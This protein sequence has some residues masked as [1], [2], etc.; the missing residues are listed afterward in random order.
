MLPIAI[1]IVWLIVGFFVF[2]QACDREV[3]ANRTNRY[4]PSMNIFEW[5]AILPLIPIMFGLVCYI[6]FVSAISDP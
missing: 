3:K 2:G 1:A 6:L 4:L 5:I